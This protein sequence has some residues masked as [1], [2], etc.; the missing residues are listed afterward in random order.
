MAHVT[1]QAGEHAAQ[2]YVHLLAVHRMRTHS[3][4]AAVAEAFERAWGTPLPPQPRPSVALTPGWVR[5][6]RA[7]VP[8]APLLD[9]SGVL[10]CVS[11][12]VACTNMTGE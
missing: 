10:T 6:G 9:R 5:I 2:H 8:R 1:Q 7:C 11:L 4:R 12:L 3:D